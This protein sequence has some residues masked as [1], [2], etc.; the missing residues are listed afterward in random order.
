MRWKSWS[1]NRKIIFYMNTENESTFILDK[2]AP[3]SLHQTGGDCLDFSLC[4]RSCDV[5]PSRFLFL[6]GVG[7]F[8]AGRCIKPDIFNARFGSGSGC[9]TT[10]T[11]FRAC[12]CG[13]F[14]PRQPCWPYP[15]SDCQELSRCIFNQTYIEVAKTFYPF[16]LSAFIILLPDRT[17]ATCCFL[18][19]LTIHT[20]CQ[21][22][23][24]PK[25]YL[26]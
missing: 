24:N 26:L 25:T 2:C 3:V 23:C 14:L 15:R 22:L 1:N 9:F 6:S 4:Y 13:L 21:T 5:V 11:C 19:T 8:T 7:R 20:I 12:S 16:V 18:S 10:S 17:K